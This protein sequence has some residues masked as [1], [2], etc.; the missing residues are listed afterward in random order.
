M[1]LPLVVGVALAISQQLS[2][3]NT[4]SVYCEAISVKLISGELGHLMSS[5]ISI[6]KTIGT[7]IASF[8]LSKVGR[9]TV[10]LLGFFSLG[11]G[12]ILLTIGFNLI[13]DSP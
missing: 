12:S 2:G 1:W 9:K 6:V 8:V 10:I 5:F 7:L 11:I 13:D 4:I 3:I